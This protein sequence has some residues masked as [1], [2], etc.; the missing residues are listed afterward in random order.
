MNWNIHISK[1][2]KFFDDTELGSK[3][4]S[5]KSRFFIWFDKQTDIS[6]FGLYFIITMSVYYLFRAIRF[7]YDIYF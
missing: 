1:N 4:S 5:S 6:R 3:P 7:I 2:S